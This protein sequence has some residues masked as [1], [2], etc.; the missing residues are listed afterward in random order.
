MIFMSICIGI[1]SWWEKGQPN[2]ASPP[3]PLSGDTWIPEKNRFLHQ[4]DIWYNYWRNENFQDWREDPNSNATVVNSTA[5]WP[6]RETNICAHVKGK[7][8]CNGDSGGKMMSYSECWFMS[9][10][11]TKLFEPC[12]QQLGAVWHRILGS[13]WVCTPRSTVHIFR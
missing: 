8:P 4:I 11:F 13:S 7:S 1:A 6:I 12:D 9:Q 3:S 2:R 10:R 5:T